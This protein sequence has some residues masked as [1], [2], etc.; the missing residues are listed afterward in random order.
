MPELDHYDEEK[1]YSFS[2]KE[3]YNTA[4]ERIKAPWRYDL[5]NI[6]RKRKELNSPG[7]L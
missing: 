2:R 4:D 6:D 3:E 7:L 5:S 1:G